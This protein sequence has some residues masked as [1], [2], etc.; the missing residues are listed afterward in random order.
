MDDLYPNE[1]RRENIFVNNTLSACTCNIVHNELYKFDDAVT[2]NPPKIDYAVSALRCFQLRGKS[3]YIR[4]IAKKLNY[5]NDEEDMSCPR[6]LCKV[7]RSINRVEQL[8]PQIDNYW[9]AYL[10]VGIDMLVAA[11]NNDYA[12]P[13]E[14]AFTNKIKLSLR[15]SDN[16][17]DLRNLCNIIDG[18]QQVLSVSKNTYDCWQDAK[19][20]LGIPTIFR[21][22]F[23]RSSDSILT[24]PNW[25]NDEQFRKSAFYLVNIWCNL[26]RMYVVKLGNLLNSNNPQEAA[27]TEILFKRE[28]EQLRGQVAGLVESIGRAGAIADGSFKINRNFEIAC[29][30]LNEFKA[31]F[32]IELDKLKSVPPNEGPGTVPM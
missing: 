20:M 16:E 18:L 9:G 10:L 4:E 11:Q 1:E 25:Y 19:K 21:T 30:E 24:R 13:N 26:E 8:A 29:F 5:E 6:F 31:K 28:V 2:D 22:I 23:E 3:E 15:K 12:L 32:K 14:F 17:A 7:F 27:R